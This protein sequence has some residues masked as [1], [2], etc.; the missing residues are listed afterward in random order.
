VVEFFFTLYLLSGLLK[1]ILF[2]FNI[3]PKIDF[4]LLTAI[5]LILST[6][7]NFIIK[8]QS[9]NTFRNLNWKF[10]LPVFAFF[11]WSLVTLSYDDSMYPFF[12]GSNFSK[13]KMIY[14]FTCSVSFIAPFIASDFSLRRFSKILITCSLVIGLY[15]ILFSP[16]MYY[17]NFINGDLNQPRLDIAFPA[18][19]EYHF[20]GIHEYMGFNFEKSM[21]NSLNI[22]LFLGLSILLAIGLQ[23]IR[24]KWILINILFIV[25]FSTAGRGPIVFSLVL[26]LLNIT[27]SFIKRIRLVE[28]KNSLREILLEFKRFLSPNLKFLFLLLVFNSAISFFIFQDPALKTMYGKT[29]SR[30]EWMARYMEDRNNIQQ[31]YISRFEKKNPQL[32]IPKTSDSTIKNSSK[33]DNSILSR[34]LFI[35]EVP[36]LANKELFHLF[37]GYGLGNYGKISKHSFSPEAHPH[38]IFIEVFLELGILG[39]LL[40]LF[41]LVPIITH[42]RSIEPALILCFIFLLLNGLKSIPVF[43]RTFFG[44]FAIILIQISE[45]KSRRYSPKTIDNFSEKEFQTSTGAI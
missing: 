37:F 42:F 30:L 15:H 2:S 3:N 40:F 27:G 24:K 6:V 44:F 45:S 36:D 26:I 10:L 25:L 31:E 4:T 5:L 43:D 34:E 19:L 9:F 28:Q 1:G 35:R 29:F 17:I 12:K 23:D 20:N 32:G 33:V 38:N 14:L 8:R 41:C 22:S 7:L 21:G 39:L 16:A 18:F 13:L 11:L